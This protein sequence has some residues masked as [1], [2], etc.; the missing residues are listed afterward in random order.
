MVANSIEDWVKEEEA[1]YQKEKMG[2]EIESFKLEK[3][4]TEGPLDCLRVLSEKPTLVRKPKVG[5][6]LL[7]SRKLVFHS[8]C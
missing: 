5:I 7:C 2:K 4:M 6:F 3:A 8:K 1:K